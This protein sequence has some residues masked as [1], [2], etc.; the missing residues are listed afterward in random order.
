MA[1]KNEGAR[2]IEAVIP[3]ANTID[4]LPSTELTQPTD[5]STDLSLDHG[6]NV[7]ATGSTVGTPAIAANA[8]STHQCIKCEARATLVC[9]RCAEGFDDNGDRSPTWYSSRECQIDHREFHKIQCKL[10]IDRRQLFR[11]GVL[12]QHAFYA[13]TKAF[14]YDEILEVRNI[15]PVEDDGAQ[16]YLCRRNDHN[17]PDFPVFPAEVL[18]AN[19]G[20]LE[21][22]DEQA[23]LAA[24]VLTG[25]VVSGLL[26]KLV[27]GKQVLSG[28][29]G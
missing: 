11:I 19:G 22:R 27:E 29:N 7:A 9:S 8:T 2:S 1:S 16:V 28:R 26:K 13:S 14:W 23:V 21:E 17:C 15:E 18:A 25:N 4:A 20:T 3:A 5:T 24:S 6:A 10:A 12:V